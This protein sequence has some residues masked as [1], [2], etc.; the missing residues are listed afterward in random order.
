MP[1]RKCTKGEISSF[2]DIEAQLADEDEED[3]L[4]GD[5]QVDD[6]IED[7]D[8]NQELED[9]DS[10]RQALSTTLADGG[11]LA[12]EWESMLAR[13][14]ERSRS[15]AQPHDLEGLEELK[16][17]PELWRVAVKAGSEELATFIL[18]QKWARAPDTYPNVK[19]IVGNRGRAG[20][21][22]LEANSQADV[23]KLCSNV[24]DIYAHHIFH[25]P[26]QESRASIKPPPF[27][28]LKIHTWVRLHCR[29]SI[30]HGDLAYVKE[31]LDGKPSGLV[32]VP[33]IPATRGQSRRRHGKRIRP[34][35]AK[36]SMEEFRRIYGE[37]MEVVGDPEEEE[38]KFRGNHF[39]DGFHLLDAV[40][41][42]ECRP[43]VP[44][45][46]EM[47]MFVDSVLVHSIA[48]EAA[49][50][51]LETSRVRVGD[52]VRVAKGDLRGAYGRVIS[53]NPDGTMS[54]IQLERDHALRPEVPTSALRK[55]LVAGDHVKVVDGAEAGSIGWVISVVDDRLTLWNQEDAREFS[56]LSSSVVFYSA[57]LQLSLT[58]S[59][60]TIPL[61][62]SPILPSRIEQDPNYHLKGREV[63]ITGK[64]HHK[65]YV[66][67]IKNTLLD[68][69]VVVEVEAGV[70]D[71]V[72]DLEKV[73]DRNLQGPVLTTPARTIR[74]SQAT[75]S[76]SIPLPSGTSV[77]IGPA[78]RPPSRT[79]LSSAEGSNPSSTGESALSPAWN[80]SSR[81]PL[82]SSHFPYNPYM[83]F[84]DL[85]QKLRVKV[86][87]KTDGGQSTGVWQAGDFVSGSPSMVRVRFGAKVD[88]VHERYLEPVR[89][90]Q[91]GQHVISIDSES[92]RF[93]QE[94]YVMDIGLE[95]CLLRPWI[96]KKEKDKSLLMPKRPR[97]PT[98]SPVVRG[99]PLPPLF[100][101]SNQP[102]GLSDGPYSP[103]SN[104]TLTSL[105]S[106][107]ES[108]PSSPTPVGPTTVEMVESQRDPSVELLE[109]ANEQRDPSVELLEP[110]Y[111][112]REA[113]VELLNSANESDEDSFVEMLE[114]EKDNTLPTQF[115]IW[116]KADMPAHRFTFLPRRSDQ[117]V[118]LTDYAESLAKKNVRWRED[119]FVYNW[120]EHAWRKPQ[121]H[122]LC[123][124][125]LRFRPCDAGQMFLLKVNNGQ[126]PFP[127]IAKPFRFDQERDHALEVLRLHQELAQRPSLPNDFGIFTGPQMGFFGVVSFF[128]VPELADFFFGKV[129][130]PPR[131]EF[132]FYNS[133]RRY[134]PI[135]L[136]PWLLYDLHLCTCNLTP[137][138][139]K[140]SGRGPAPPVASEPER[141]STLAYNN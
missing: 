98:S 40:D 85:N 106:E 49:T 20:Y 134:N 137:S 4:G 88:E 59:S 125:G 38:F 123:T 133:S 117:F 128:L 132:N 74:S 75:L 34:P 80:P 13:A 115:I 104:S 26:E 36:V 5:D 41:G 110:A 138:P 62:S 78:W 135:R 27:F 25:V 119:F 83:V 50:A 65:G 31:G 95:S 69:R 44:T 141:A 86:V 56:V 67:Y 122:N 45:S 102:L 43:A 71:V 64:S 97:S 101:P 90:T 77:A 57:P 130:A 22:Y 94:F 81:T 126:H 2:L 55:H 14:R 139:P 54:T 3:A 140:V 8:D 53:M 35:Q 127:G 72:V 29:G 61:A 16:F 120:Q 99:K 116:S 76:P 23:L 12:D 68:N 112:Q 60:T 100:V 42:V 82:T 96:K 103:S 136:Q 92:F 73:S 131:S 11:S 93:C 32:V 28:H 10:A 33:R 24:S 129:A 113:S 114:P 19:S 84:P 124:L 17:P 66:G 70:K 30:Y 46:S 9:W 111:E 18:Y 47:A 51:L 63:T 87:R 6:L 52:P 7:E 107:S 121:A 15:Y 91:K 105:S 37:E 39:R 1:P 109:P 108:E 21:I 58:T 79:P 89:P 48:V 118:Y